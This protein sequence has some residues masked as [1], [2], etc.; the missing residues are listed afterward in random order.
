MKSVLREGIGRGGMDALG[1]CT[2][3]TPHEKI[4]PVRARIHELRL[5]VGQPRSLI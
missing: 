4:D 1:S 2:G 3:W 5:S